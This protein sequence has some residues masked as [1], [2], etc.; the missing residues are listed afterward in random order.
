MKVG[1]LVERIRI[2]PERANDPVTIETARN[3]GYVF[4]VIGTIYTVREIRT[5]KRLSIL[6]E[7]IVNPKVQTVHGFLE[8]SWNVE[9]FRELQPPMDLSFIKELQQPQYE[10]V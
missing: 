8:I 9:S 6:L 2:R 1:S 3:S 5:I 10:T 7:E 4:P